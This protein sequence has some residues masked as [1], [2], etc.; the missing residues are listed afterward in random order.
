VKTAIVGVGNILM[1]DDGIGVL[2][3]REVEKRGSPDG[4]RCIDGGTAAFG[5]LDEAAG[6]ERI[7]VVDAVKAG[8][9]PGTIYRLTFDEWQVNRQASLHDVQ[10]MDAIALAQ[11]LERR[12]VAVTVIGIEPEEVSL[13]LELSTTVK[14]RF[15]DLVN[16][17][18]EEIERG[19]P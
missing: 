16:A 9:T 18:L 13:G 3:A 2:V 4:V 11:A 6:C 1:R 8:G 12:E 17:V 10:F 5:A 7:I 19:I 14:R 15:Q